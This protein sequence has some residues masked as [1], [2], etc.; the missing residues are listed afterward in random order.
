[1]T[2]PQKRRSP[3]SAPHRFRAQSKN[4]PDTLSRSAREIAATILAAVIFAASVWSSVFGM[5]GQ[6][7]P[8]PEV[9]YKLAGVGADGR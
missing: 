2:E 7:G 9:G 6:F 3:E 4:S 5:T 8:T 1:M